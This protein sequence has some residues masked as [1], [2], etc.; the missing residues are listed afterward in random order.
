MAGDGGYLDWNATGPMRPEVRLAVGEAEGRYWANPS[1]P[2]GAGRAA[3]AAVDRARTQ[4]AAW[5][6]RDPRQ[7]VFT[8]GATEANA[9]ALTGLRT[10]ARP[11]VA[12]SAVEHPS[13]LAHGDWRIPVDAAGR[14]LVAALDRWLVEAG[15][16]V[17]VVSVMAANN[18][19]G[20]LQPLDDVARC[21]AAHRVPL[22]VDATQCF[23][24]VDAPRHGDLVTVSPHKG[25]GPKGV[26]ALV[27]DREIRALLP[28]GPQERGRRAGTENV[29]AIV[30]FAAAAQLAG[31]L[32][33]GARDGLEAACIAAGGRI[34]GAGAPR[35]PNTVAALF[36]A[37]G[38]LVVMALDMAGFAV[39]TGSACASGA[40]GTS[41]VVAAMGQ[42]GVPVRFSTGFSTG[43]VTGA[44]EAIREVVAQVEAACGS[45]QP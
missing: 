11:L 40:P 8:S 9:L 21:C 13:V 27:V 41:H 45:S 12:V 3:R 23:G 20:V 38:D 33:A 1:A 30:G 37:P 10:T 35:L 43:D 34:L 14:V 6:D 36:D 22:H 39:S 31:V 29:P 19:T 5:L 18:E 2:H 15:G 16:R 32:D 17:A 24:R 4:V 26:G 25:G 28:G 7:L 44:A 42:D